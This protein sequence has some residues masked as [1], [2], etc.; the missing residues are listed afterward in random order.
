MKENEVFCKY[1]K[2]RVEKFC[3]I[4]NE[5]VPRKGSCDKAMRKGVK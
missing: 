5:Y 4:K 3:K 2:Y 1:C